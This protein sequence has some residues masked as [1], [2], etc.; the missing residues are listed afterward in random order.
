MCVCVSTD[1][2]DYTILNIF[3]IYLQSVFVHCVYV[4][5]EEAFSCAVCLHVQLDIQLITFE[6][7]CQHLIKYM[8]V[9]ARMCGCVCLAT[10]NKQTGSYS[11][12]HKPRY[13]YETGFFCEAKF[14]INSLTK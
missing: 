10:E 5:A 3:H 12:E 9:Q 4:T 14:T 13:F 6:D 2:L 11:H 1:H 8:A 7:L